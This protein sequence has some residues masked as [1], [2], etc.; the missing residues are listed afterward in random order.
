MEESGFVFLPHT[1]YYVYFT[2]L[3]APLITCPANI[4]STQASVS[5]IDPSA[6]DNVDS[7]PVIS[8]NPSSGSHFDVGQTIVTCTATDHVGNQNSCDFFVNAGMTY[9]F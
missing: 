1:D 3:E 9:F 6:T 4:S 5:W 7:S 8:C 2:D